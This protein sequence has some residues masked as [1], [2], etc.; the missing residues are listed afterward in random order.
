MRKKSENRIEK[1]QI[2]SRLS[3]RVK[4]IQKVNKPA[5][6]QHNPKLFKE[7]AFLIDLHWT[8]SNLSD[9]GSESRGVTHLL[10][11]VLY[12]RS[13]SSPHTQPTNRHQK[14][15]NF[16]ISQPQHPTQWTNDLLL[17][18]VLN[19]QKTIMFI[20]AQESGHLVSGCL[21]SEHTACLEK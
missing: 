3:A 20:M 2:K 13:T 5:F 12:I 7:Y 1:E 4:G 8:T 9:S 18:L 6:Y 14:H 16:V 15:H 17:Y 21:V 11:L 19:W 10:L